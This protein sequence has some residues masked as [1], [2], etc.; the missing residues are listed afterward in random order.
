[1]EYKFSDA[2]LFTEKERKIYTTASGEKLDLTWHPS[3]VDSLYRE[4]TELLAKVGQDYALFQTN[5][6]I[7]KTTK[8]P[9]EQLKVITD[10]IELMDSFKSKGYQIIMAALKANGREVDD[11]WLDA[12]LLAEEK[13]LLVQLIMD[14]SDNFILKTKKK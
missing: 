1:M 6:E 14:I 10:Y 3:I 11:K 4:Y 5:L 7:A 13:E 2:K 8:L 9:D 12:N